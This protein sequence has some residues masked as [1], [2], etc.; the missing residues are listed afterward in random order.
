MKVGLVIC[1]FNRPAYLKRLFDSL[2]RADLSKLNRICIVDDASTDIET[3]K[4]INSFW[5][6]NVDTYK[7]IKPQRMSKIGRASCRERV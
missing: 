7:I 4:L 1:T 3:K 2:R 6:P 5:I